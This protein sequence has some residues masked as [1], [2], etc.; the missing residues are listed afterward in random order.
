MAR[1]QFSTTCESNARRLPVMTKQIKKNSGLYINVDQVPEIPQKE[2][3]R[4]PRKGNSKAHKEIHT[5]QKKYTLP[6]RFRSLLA[7]RSLLTARCSQMCSG[8]TWDPGLA[9]RR[10]YNSASLWPQPSDGQNIILNHMRKRCLPVAV[11]DRTG[12]YMS[13]LQINA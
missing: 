4:A 6:A 13:G 9:G 2:P 12:N 8:D 5:S 1:T 3:K 10:H 11:D 7:A